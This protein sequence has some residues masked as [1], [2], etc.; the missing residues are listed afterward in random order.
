MSVIELR[1]RIINEVNSMEDVVVLQEIHDLIKMETGVESVYKL[2]SQ[3]KSAVEVGLK[4]I[5]EDRIASSEGANE[6]IA[7]W[8]RK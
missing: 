5:K 6:R 7:Q 3:K 8:L 1:K 2:T 4:D